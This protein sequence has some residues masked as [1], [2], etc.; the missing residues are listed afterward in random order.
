MRRNTNKRSLIKIRNYT[1]FIPKT[2]KATRRF[3]KAAVNRIGY[4][5]KNTTSTLK[6]TTKRL[7]KRMA[8]SIGSLTK[9]HSRK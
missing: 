4:F 6:K 8:R 7:D 3:S 2:M 9:K 5:L 1:A